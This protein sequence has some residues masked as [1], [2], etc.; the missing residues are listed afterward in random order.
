[1]L[2]GDRWIPWSFVAFFAVVLIAN[3]SLVVLAVKSWPGLETSSAYQ[4]GLA[5]NKML[6]AASEQAELGWKVGFHFVQ[7][8]PRRG[9]V[10]V[11]LEDRFG[12]LLRQAEV[13]AQF[14]RPTSEGSDLRLHLAHQTG[15]RYQ[16]EVE[17]PLEGQWDVRIAASSNGQ[18]YRLSER[19]FLRP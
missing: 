14:V 15:G 8:G 17:L 11:D 3:G 1:M 12:N 19:I 5:Y 9:V 6:A 4:R 10:Q 13:R 2:R 7:D 16:A 18:I